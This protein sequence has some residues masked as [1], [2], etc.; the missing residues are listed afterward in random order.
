MKCGMTR[1]EG[2]NSDELMQAQG[3]KRQTKPQNKHLTCKEIP[4][5]RHSRRSAPQRTPQEGENGNKI[6]K[7]RISNKAAKDGK[8]DNNR[9][10]K[11]WRGKHRKTGNFFLNNELT[12]KPKAY[13]DQ[14]LSAG[15]VG[16][17]NKVS[18]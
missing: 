5:V 17:N 15:K 16:K 2:K 10:M 4:C 3:R 6:R 1:K 14:H 9:K 13:V 18:D 12:R 7:T 11:Y 8:N